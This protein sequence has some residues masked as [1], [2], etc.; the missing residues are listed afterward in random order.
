MPKVTLYNPKH[1]LYSDWQKT[2]ILD[3]DHKLKRTVVKQNVELK[4][5]AKEDNLK[6]LLD[7][8]VTS[9][10]VTTEGGSRDY[11]FHDEQ[12]ASLLVLGWLA[13]AGLPAEIECATKKYT[14]CPIGIGV[15]KSLDNSNIEIKYSS[16]V[17]DLTDPY[18]ENTAILNFHL[19]P[20][21]TIDS[22]KASIQNSI[23]QFA[24]KLV[25]AVAFFET[26]K[27]TNSRKGHDLAGHGFR[28]RVQDVLARNACFAA[29]GIAHP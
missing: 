26:V 16:P 13:A 10:K 5:P 23:N 2:Y 19:S 14:L 9:G 15:K 20:G 24:P 8:L 7:L 27:L 4:V 21:G 29:N 25:N 22:A 3:A 18:G 11:D 6:L 1:P 17:T 12:K 28:P